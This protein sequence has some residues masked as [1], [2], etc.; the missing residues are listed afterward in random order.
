MSS[1]PLPPVRRAALAKLGAA[2]REGR[3]QAGVSQPRAAGLFDVSVWTYRSWEHGRRAP[4]DRPAVAAPRRRARAGP[5]HLP[6]L[7]PA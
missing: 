7:P 6:V 4:R 2:L 1:N 5:G 3:T